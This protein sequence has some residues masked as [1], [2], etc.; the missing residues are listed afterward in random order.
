MSSCKKF[1]FL[2]S[3]SFFIITSVVGDGSHGQ[4][5]SSI[6]TSQNGTEYFTKNTTKVKKTKISIKLV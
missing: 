3:I 4:S 6:Q 5:N 2:C 1:V